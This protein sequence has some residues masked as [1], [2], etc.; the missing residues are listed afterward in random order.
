MQLNGGDFGIVTRCYFSLY[1][2]VVPVVLLGFGAECWAYGNTFLEH[3][4]LQEQGPATY[5]A[6]TYATNW[7]GHG[8]SVK[9]CVDTLNW[10]SLRTALS[11]YDIVQGSLKCNYCK[12]TYHCPMYRVN[13]VSMCSLASFYS[14]TY[15][16]D[17]NYGLGEFWDL[18][19]IPRCGYFTPCA[20]Y[21]RALQR[22][23]LKFGAYVQPYK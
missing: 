18:Q 23:P 16:D 19:C 8:D 2:R 13:S 3:Y 7:A 14:D 9:V 12:Y 15:S 22:G 21:S 4:H 6:D 17:G 5:G 10:D 20:G 11:H 1:K